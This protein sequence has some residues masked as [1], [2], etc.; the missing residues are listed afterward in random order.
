MRD[1]LERYRDELHRMRL[2][3]ESKRPLPLAAFHI[4]M[5]C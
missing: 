1:E 2:T 3:E 4:F 5:R